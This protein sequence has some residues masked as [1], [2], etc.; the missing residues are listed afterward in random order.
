MIN[1]IITFFQKPAA[2]TIDSVISDIR[3]KVRQLDN[4]AE[5]HA[6]RNL[7]E[8]A[9]QVS[10]GIRADEEG[11]AADRATRLANKFNDLIS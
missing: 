3:N 8:R 10:A 5:K 11:Q 4:L 7:D 1:S 6:Q 9:A 2:I